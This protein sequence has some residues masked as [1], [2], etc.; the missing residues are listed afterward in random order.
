MDSLTLAWPDSADRERASEVQ[1]RRRM[2]DGRWGQDLAEYL[3]EVLH[4]SRRANL[5]R[6]SRAVNLYKSTVQQISCLYDSA[7]TVTHP[8][9][10]EEMQALLAELGWAGLSQKHALYVYGLRESAYKIDFDEETLSP[11]LTLITPDELAVEVSPDNPALI[12]VLRHARLRQ[13][14]EDEKKECYYY[15][16]YDLSDLSA[17]Q[18]RVEDRKRADVTGAFGLTRD[19][20]WVD[21]EGAFFPFVIYHAAP[22]G[23]PWD[24]YELA[25]LVDAAFDVGVLWN[26][27]HHVMRDASW[28]QK[29]GLN[30]ELA[31]APGTTQNGQTQVVTSPTSLL[32]FRSSD[33]GGGQLG[34]LEPAVDPE[35]FARAVLTY[36]RT[37]VSTLGLAAT[38]L[39]AA[40]AESGV[41]ITLRRSAQR[42]MA[43][44]LEPQFRQ[45]DL[46]LFGKLARISNLFAGTVWPTDGY[47]VSYAP[48]PEA[49]TDQSEQFDFDAKMVANGLMSRTEWYQR[50]HPGVGADEARAALEA[51]AEENRQLS[52]EA[53]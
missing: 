33:V 23:A 44:R 15:D 11:T 45:G 35:A 9:P 3:S 2:L 29:Y 32:L 28:A 37:A 8:E 48:P 25:E 46:Q 7:P 38:D 24:C 20:P 1:R 47:R 19:Y 26:S 30:V 50:T 18:F 22:S 51:I 13:S 31:G 36:Q 40:S 52:Q 43:A 49:V 53:K 34:V 5:G 6:L 4:S 41:A 12:R 42:R 17:P 27:Y 16:T 39:E 21:E 10:I 14:L